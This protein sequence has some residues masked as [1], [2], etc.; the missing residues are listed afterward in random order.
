MADADEIPLSKEEQAFFDA[1]KD[2]DAPADDE[3]AATEEAPASTIGTI[4]EAA[5]TDAP[6][7][8]TTETNGN[9]QSE[10]K[11]EEDDDEEGIAS[12]RMEGLEDDTTAAATAVP[13]VSSSA[14]PEASSATSVSVAI[15]KDENHE[16]RAGSQSLPTTPVIQQQQHHQQHQQKST[17]GKR[18]RLPQ[19]LVGQLEDRIAENP[20]GDVDAWLSLIDEHKRKGKFDDARAVYERFFQVFPQAVGCP[21]VKGRIEKL[22]ADFATGPAMDRLRPHG[23]RKQRAH[24]CRASLFSLSPHR[25]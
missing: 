13:S 22:A 18:K 14:A 7:T 9:E 15:P 8:E 23:T 1:M 12:G 17:G 20:R 4:E 24:A 19:D 10:V 16:T 6:T 21:G 5:T 2:G 11:E 25:A 3:S